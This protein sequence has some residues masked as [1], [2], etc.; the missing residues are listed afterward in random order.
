[1]GP[2]QSGRSICWV[3]DSFQGPVRAQF[4]GGEWA[5][6]VA[7]WTEKWAVPLAAVTAIKGE[8]RMVGLLLR[9]LDLVSW[10]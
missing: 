5:R 6:R 1:M 2:S 9:L 8:E 7:L 4:S 3:V 10:W